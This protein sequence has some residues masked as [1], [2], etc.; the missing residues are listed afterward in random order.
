MRH[1]L[2]SIVLPFVVCAIFHNDAAAQTRWRA[3]Y[4]SLAV[5]QVALSLGVRAG[6]FQKNGLNLEPIY[7]GGR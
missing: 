5:S 3:S 2:H 6:I 1:F 7:F 4:G